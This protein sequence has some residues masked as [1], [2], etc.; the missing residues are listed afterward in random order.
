V[1]RRTTPALPPSSLPPRSRICFFFLRF[2]SLTAYRTIVVARVYDFFFRQL[3]RAC[4]SVCSFLSAH[5]DDVSQT[6]NS[7]DGVQTCRDY[8]DGGPAFAW[9]RRYSCTIIFCIS[10]V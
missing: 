1:E 8:S 3:A 10:L 7:R 5:D 2:R 6:R 9:R 4:V